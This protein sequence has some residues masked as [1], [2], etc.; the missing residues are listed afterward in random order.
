M[1]DRRLKRELIE[2]G[3]LTTWSKRSKHSYMESTPLMHAL[4]KRGLRCMG[5]YS[6]GV[7]NALRP[8]LRQIRFVF[9]TLPEAFHGFRILHLSDLHA[10]GLVGLAEAL[11]PQ[12][13]SLEVDLCVLTG[14]YR[15]RTFGPCCQVY[16]NMARI[17]ASV[18]AR[19]GIMGILGNHDVSEMV[20]AFRELGVRMLMN[21][22]YALQL[23]SQRIW[24]IGVDDP[25]HYGC[26][27][28]PGALRGVPAQ[29]FKILLVH[30]PEILEEAH[31]G[32]I[33]LYL[34]GHTHG[35]Q[36]RLPLIG[37]VIT[38]VDCPR[39]CVRGAWQ[40]KSVC[41][42]TSPGVGCSGVTAR[43]LCPPELVLIELCCTSL[44]A[45]PETVRHTA[46]RVALT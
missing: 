19:H 42:Y 12:L 28:L 38:N 25:H 40:Y 9:D 41:G 20:P 7:R 46:R 22:S 30:T 21:E 35:G 10:D 31:Q 14:D 18:Q 36:I 4:L 16:P 8:E 2:R 39:V 23:E 5:L 6:R 3:E 29:A 32:G 15:F 17:L 11:A 43:F 45:R 24:L 37:P 44:L 1:T 13:Q 27:D 26:D 33:Q 34:C